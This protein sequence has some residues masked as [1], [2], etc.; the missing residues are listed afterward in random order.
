[1]LLKPS[2]LV[3]TCAAGLAS[4][5]AIQSAWILAAEL[6]R[7]KTHFF[8]RTGIDARDAATHNSAAAAA[9]RIG[10]PR[11]DLWNDYAVTANAPVV[12]VIEDGVM[13]TASS[14]NNDTGHVAERAARLAP[15]DPRA[16]LLLAMEN[17]RSESDEGKAL[18]QMKMSYY[19]SPYNG[20]LFPLRMQIAARLPGITDEE[21]NSFVE[22]ELGIAIRKNPSLKPSIASAYRAAGSAGRRFFETTLEKQDPSFL[23]ELKTTKP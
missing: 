5:L 13:P 8:P 14:L 21:L 11:G 15:S 1:M 7:P 16:W 22:Y 19:T 12:S 6:T 9:A 20:D 10:W 18:A 4:I 23:A 3:R 17:M 2:S